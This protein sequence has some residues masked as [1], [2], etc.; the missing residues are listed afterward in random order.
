MCIRD[1]S[2][3]N[4]IDDDPVAE[5]D[6]INKCYGNSVTL[7]RDV[8]DYETACQVILSLCETVGA[9]LRADHVQCR[10]VCVELKDWEFHC[11]SHQMPL[12]EPTDST[13]ILFEYSCR[14]LR[15]FWDQTPVRLVGVRAGKIDDDTFSQIS[16]FDTPQSRKKKE[17]ERAV[18]QIR[19]KFGVDSIK[20]MCIRD[21][22]NAVFFTS[23]VYAWE[24]F[25]PSDAAA[26]T[27]LIYWCLYRLLPCTLNF[28]R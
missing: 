14:L 3:A 12:P 23:D 28:F 2:Y 11:Q 7:S 9:R 22:S 21:S 19:N 4:G 6:P 10:N 8:S 1:S 13:A 25:A 26:C 5:K 24:S 27:L 16:L 17:L 15:E 18:D 20:Q